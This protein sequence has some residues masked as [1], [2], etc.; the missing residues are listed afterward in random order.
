MQGSGGLRDLFRS[1]RDDARGTGIP[2]R[3]KISFALYSRNFIQ[4]GARCGTTIWF[5]MSRS[6]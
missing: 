6:T 2:Y 4:V 1:V 3:A 5:L